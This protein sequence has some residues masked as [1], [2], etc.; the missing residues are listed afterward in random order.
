MN[1]ERKQT[2]VCRKVEKDENIS[3][4]EF[5]QSVIDYICLKVTEESMTGKNSMTRIFNGNLR[6]IIKRQMYQLA[7]N[8]NTNEIFIDYLYLPCYQTWNYLRHFKIT[9]EFSELLLSVVEDL[10]LVEFLMDQN[11]YMYKFMGA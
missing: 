7:R 8:N 11:V 2:S 3:Y 9:L 4:D 1:R 6:L 10:F 5:Q